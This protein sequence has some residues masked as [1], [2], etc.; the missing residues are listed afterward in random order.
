MSG[1]AIH[2]L[3]C[4]RIEVDFIE[5]WLNH[6]LN[7]GIDHIFIYNSGPKIIYDQKPQWIKVGDAEKIIQEKR[8]Y[9]LKDKRSDDEIESLWEDR[10]S[11]Y[12]FVTKIKLQR[13]EKLNRSVYNQLQTELNF[14]EL[15]KY[16]E[17]G[18]DWVFNI[19]GD[20][21]LCGELSFLKEVPEMVSRVQIGQY[22]Y[23]DRFSISGERL[24]V[25]NLLPLSGSFIK[26]CNKNI[27]RPQ[28]VESWGNVHYEVKLKPT[29]KQIWADKIWFNHYR[30][31]GYKETAK[32][33]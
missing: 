2:A 27:V 21:F 17:M 29:K 11:K 23:E 19:D 6:H 31:H 7:F 12:P 25:K 26:I 5:D 15:S 22:C 24:S 9:L 3:M 4:P 28:D 13:P 33:E 18:F 16:S 32:Q 20:E 10:L 14:S 30:G 1:I 8:P